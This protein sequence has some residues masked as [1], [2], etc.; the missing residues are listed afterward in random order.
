MA[1]RCRAQYRP[2]V[3]IITRPLMPR[4]DSSRVCRHVD[5]AGYR[6]LSGLKTMKPLVTWSWTGKEVGTWTEFSPR[7]N[8]ARGGERSTPHDG[9]SFVTRRRPSP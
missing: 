9:T 2:F 4:H 8:H 6:A 1:A 5:R 3:T 7:R